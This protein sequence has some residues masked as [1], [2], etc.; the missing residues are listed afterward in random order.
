METFHNN[1][2]NIDRNTGFIRHSKRE[3]ARSK[4]G[5]YGLYSEKKAIRGEG[6]AA[7]EKVPISNMIPLCKKKLYSI[8]FASHRHQV[9]RCDTNN[10]S[11]AISTKHAEHPLTDQV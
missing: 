8:I 6:E 5:V 10:L 9:I 11:I 7:G 1:Q 3:V 2:A 4:R